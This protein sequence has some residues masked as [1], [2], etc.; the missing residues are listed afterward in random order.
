M[1]QVIPK[2]RVAV[3]YDTAKAPLILF[4]HDNHLSNVLRQLATMGFEKE[5]YSMSIELVER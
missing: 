4:V 3:C 5:P 1:M 2:W